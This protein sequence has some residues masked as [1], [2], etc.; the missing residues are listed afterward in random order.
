MPAMPMREQTT[1]RVE[2]GI[3]QRM[4][5]V[6]D[7]A[8]AFGTSTEYFAEW[9]AASYTLSRKMI[10]MAG[11]ENGRAIRSALL[12][13]GAFEGDMRSRRFAGLPLT[14]ITSS[15]LSTRVRR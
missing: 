7:T 12:T 1:D 9:Q 15:P 13:L 2:S 5:T 11:Q 14:R 4:S 3:K 10:D 8:R 6:T